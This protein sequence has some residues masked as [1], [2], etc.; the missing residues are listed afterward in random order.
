M[1]LLAYL[2]I[3]VGVSVVGIMTICL[4]LVLFSVVQ[5]F[6]EIVQILAAYILSTRIRIVF[7]KKLFQVF[8]RC[9]VIQIPPLIV[10]NYG[11]HDY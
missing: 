9:R 10:C 7:E 2:K 5:G 6:Y 1:H 3:F 8:I 11:F 4:M